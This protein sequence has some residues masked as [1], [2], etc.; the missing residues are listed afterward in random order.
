MALPEKR[1]RRA[2][3]AAEKRV[4][5]EATHYLEH[6]FADLDSVSL[7]APP[8]VIE[9]ENLSLVLKSHPNEGTISEGL[10]LLEELESQSFQPPSSTEDWR[11]FEVFE[12]RVLG[13]KNIALLKRLNELFHPQDPTAWKLVLNGGTCEGTVFCPLSWPARRK[14]TADDKIEGIIKKC[15]VS[16]FKDRASPA[17]LE[18]EAIKRIWD[19]SIEEVG[20]GLLEGP[21]DLDGLSD[22]VEFLVPRFA[23]FQKQKYRMIDDARAFNHDCQLDRVIPLPSPLQA[24]AMA[25]ATARLQ[26]NADL[27]PRLVDCFSVN[28]RKRKAPAKA[29]ACEQ[30]EF[31]QVLL[32]ENYDLGSKISEQENVDGVVVDIEKAYKTIGIVKGHEK[33]NYIA[34]FD[35]KNEKWVA[36]RGLSL[37]FG[38]THSVV[39]WVR[40]AQLLS[41]CIRGLFSIPNSVFIDD[42]HSFIRSGL[43]PRTAFAL[44]T[45]FD[46]VGWSYKL[47]KIDVSNES[48][49]LLGLVFSLVGHP[50]LT[51]SDERKAMYSSMLEEKMSQKFLSPNEAASLYGKLS[52]ALCSVCDR[53]LRPLIRPLMVRMFQNNKDFSLNKALALS[54]RACADLIKV[55]PPRKLTVSPVRFLVYTDASWRRGKGVLAGVLVFPERVNRESGSLGKVL[56]WRLAVSESDLHPSVAK[57]PI[58]F[59]EAV[60]AIIALKVWIKLLSNSRCVFLLDNCAAEGTLHRMNSGRP[61]MSLSAFYFWLIASEFSVSPELGRVPSESNVSDL[62]TKNDEMF[63][64]F[65]EAFDYDEWFLSE[66]DRAFIFKFMK[67]EV[68]HAEILTCA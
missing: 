22:E 19:T 40:V 56:M 39:V 21:F 55:L 49:T 35:P 6:I 25:T 36:F 2:A 27:N 62:P 10:R 11:F 24:L 23:V 16:S 61:S 33:S 1:I 47:E 52:F 7:M 26:A 51:I 42:F 4:V 48:V 45:F 54:L 30:S 63:R 57:F 31:V 38:N 13:F 14:K 37:V 34:V 65:Q 58:N 66:E 59:L 67:F 64:K 3:R 32:R 20:T 29:A 46:K 9:E 41:S 5:R 44:C 50:S 68:Q 15:K 18:P 17:F 8:P 60:A 43:G 12:R 53:R 28:S